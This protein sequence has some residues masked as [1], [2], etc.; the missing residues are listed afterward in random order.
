M[1]ATGDLPT[2]K[3]IYLEVSMLLP[4]I[5]TGVLFWKFGF[6][7]I[8]LLTILLFCY[9]I[10]PGLL[11]QYFILFKISLDKVS[12]HVTRLSSSFAN[13]ALEKSE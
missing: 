10:V 7:M 1:D 5:V 8:A 9:L 3:F 6:P 11:I 4:S 13:I 12:T 2:W